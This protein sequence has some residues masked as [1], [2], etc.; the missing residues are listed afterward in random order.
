VKKDKKLFLK[1]VTL[2][3]L[4]EDTLL[5]IAAGATTPNT[6]CVKATCLEATCIQRPITNACMC[7]TTTLPPGLQ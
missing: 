7:Y 4:D 3:N 1:K 2:K 6:A 5:N